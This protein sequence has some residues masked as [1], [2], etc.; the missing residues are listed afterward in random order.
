MKI[1]IQA[2]VTLNAK[3]KNA[4]QQASTKFC[5]KRDRERESKKKRSLNEVLTEC[6]P[7]KRFF[8]SEFGNLL[9]FSQPPP[10]KTK[11]KT[12]TANRWETT[13]SKPAVANHL[14][15]SL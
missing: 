10:I 8:T 7:A 3:I 13:N 4:D 11:T 5:N 6:D 9:F 15:R 2:D 1:T 12:E 14:N